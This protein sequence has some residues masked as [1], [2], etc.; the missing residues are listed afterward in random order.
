MKFA[1]TQKRPDLRYII[2][3][4]GATKDREGCQAVVVVVLHPPPRD[5]LDPHVVRDEKA[6]AAS[7]VVARCQRELRGLQFY[8]L[9][10][11]PPSGCLEGGGA[12]D[13]ATGV[14][15]SRD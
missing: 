2:G 9:R 5:R 6:D 14:F 7:T 13:D 15:Q 3:R 10:D 12:A 4:F 1:V 8:A 11:L